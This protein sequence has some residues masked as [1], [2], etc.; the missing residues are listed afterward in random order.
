MTF[1]FKLAKRIAHSRTVV[2]RA[3][4]A[5]A[6]LAGCAD[7]FG[8]E[9]TENPSLDTAATATSVASVSVTPGAASGNIGQAAQFT[10]VARDR[11][12]RVLSGRTVTWRTTNSAVVTVSSSGMATAVGGGSAAVE[13]V[14]SGVVGRASI[15]VAGPTLSV[16][17]VTVTPGTAAGAVGESA[18]FTATVRD[19]AGNELPTVGVTWSTTN[20]GVITVTAQ[21]YATAVGGGT[22]DVIAT[23]GGKSGRASVTVAG[24][25]VVTVASVSVSPGSASGSVGESAQFSAVARDASGNV[26]TDRP[27]TWRSTNTAVVSV[28]SGGYATAIGG[29]SAAIVATIDG[30]TGEAPITVSG[31]TTPPAAAVAS[32]TLAPANVTIGVGAVQTIAVTLRDANGNILTGRPVSWSS[33][34]SLVALVSD[35]GVVSGLLAGTTTLRATS[36]GITGTATVTVSGSAPPP[37]P[38]GGTWSH[39]PSG[40][41]LVSDNPFDQTS[42]LGWGIVWNDRGLGS[43]VTDNTA[44]LSAS[45][46][47]Q[48]SFPVGYTG[49]E[50]PA[51][52]WRP[53]P[54]L[55]R[56]FT[57]FY[58]KAS[59]PWQGHPSNVN[60]ILFAFPT[61]GGDIYMAMYGPPGG[62]YELRV[63]PQFP[64]LP[65]EWLRPNVNNVHVT[66]G[67]WH[68]IEW[69]IDYSAGGSNGIVQWWMDGV[70]IGDHRNQPTPSGGFAEFKINPTWGGLGDS[71]Q[72]NDYFRYD[73]IRI[74]GN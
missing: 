48:M 59:N 71:K 31:G 29:G 28:T 42:A 39:E 22:A 6:L 20:T 65:S 45:N 62:P 27:V 60:K 35:L 11:Q 44:P 43:I 70:L 46:V 63:L 18:Q 56:M 15:T 52:V 2:L 49:G 73:H 10:A 7:S 68:K 57:G 34:N 23:A 4:A 55:R 67:D 3:L 74:S 5:V 26:I 66:L 69:N 64:G 50:G 12:G 40:Y 33:S 61:S 9:P 21:G 38:T 53:L 8:T 17:T 72:T 58:W 19:A 24:A 41:T 1:T 25:P 47:L 51:N 13:A 36:E 54:G 32:V 16:A 37:P 30:K 14:I